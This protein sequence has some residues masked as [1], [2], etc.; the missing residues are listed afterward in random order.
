M[1]VTTT[2]ATQVAD[3]VLV[4]AARHGDLFAWERLV[5]RYQE[6]VYRMAF[7]IVRDTILAEDAT[8]S[9][10]VRAYRALP[11]FDDSVGLVPWLLRIAAGEARQQR[12][13]S[14]RPKHSSRPVE[15][16]TGPR[17]PASPIAGSGQAR[18]LTPTDRSTLGDAFDR[19]GEEDRLT[20][21]L[22]YLLGL[23]RQ[24]AADALSISSGLADERLQAALQH[25]RAR[26]EDA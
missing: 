10:F 17:Y 20:L 12:R 7:L 6:A 16:I 13:E 5:R 23:S 15:R 1:S 4:E 8:R 14:G 18:A 11:T 26:M 25:L 22:R 19:L 3:A 24:D 2:S 9:T 21:A